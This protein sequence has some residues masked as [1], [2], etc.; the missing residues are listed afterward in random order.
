VFYFSPV[1]L[2]FCAASATA[3][4]PK[5]NALYPAGAER[6]TKVTVTAAGTFGH[7]PVNAWVDR[8]GL[9]VTSDT[10][11]NKL[12]VTVASDAA[13]GVYW[14][15][16][17]DDEGATSPR[18]F[19]VGTISELNESEP[20]NDRQ[21]AET[22][23]PSAV[24]INGRLDKAGD[25]DMFAVSLRQGQ[26]LVASIDANRTLGSP[27]DSV[28]QIVSPD[29][30]VLG[31]NDDY[32][33]LDSQLVLVVPADGTYFIRV[34]GFPAVPTATIG[35][36]GGEDF[37][38]RLTITS[39]AFVEYAYPLAVSV[40]SSDRDGRNSSEPHVTASVKL[41]GWNLPDAMQN[42]S[43]QLGS[44]VRS[45]E[46]ILPD[47]A[48]SA[49]VRREPH[50]TLMEQEPNGRESP[51]EIQLPVTITGRIDKRGDVDI[52]RLRAK[53]DEKLVFRAESRTLGFPLDPLLRLTDAAGKT[54][55]EV[56]DSASGRDA[57]LA[58][59]IPDDGEYRLMIRDLHGHGGDRYVYRLSGTHAEPDFSLKVAA[60]SFVLTPGKTLEVA[61]TVDRANGFASEIELVAERLVDGILAPAVKSAASGDT[62]KT[63]K[64]TLSAASGPLAGPFRIVGRVPGQPDFVRTAQC[65]V[66]NLS[67]ATTD[68][69]VTVLKGP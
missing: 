31:E 14:V 46:I 33:D 7:W 23:A 13:P 6:G 29:G 15:R 47:V 9:E 49:A 4:P 54:L 59:T 40:S 30:F 34:F 12:T 22:V 36:A 35:F 50:A 55:A 16:F 62:A 2:A 65:P 57:E 58:F 67:A 25:V 39:D 60:D 61:V 48:G 66:A 19:V 28:L 38:Y 8:P 44:P 3:A 37:V 68:L 21:T 18:P 56:D 1:I 10:D 52:F 64:L 17:Y 26:T 51:Q 27:M 45:Q 20:N 42:W 69:W 32:H 43:V 24:V 5:L 11:K 41:H 53:K 63:V